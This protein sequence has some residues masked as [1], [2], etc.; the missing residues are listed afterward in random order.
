MTKYKWQPFFQSMKLQNLSMEE[1]EAQTRSV[2]RILKDEEFLQLFSR[3]TGMPVEK[4]LVRLETYKCWL[5]ESQTMLSPSSPLTPEV[6][7]I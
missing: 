1:L 4:L 2:E 5:K 7:N 6:Q 3:Q